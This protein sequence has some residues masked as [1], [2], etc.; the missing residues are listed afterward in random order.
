[1]CSS[2]CIAQMGI[3]FSIERWTWKLSSW[4][5]YKLERILYYSVISQEQMKMF[6][7][8]NQLQAK[9]QHK[10]FILN[11]IY[12]KSVTD[13]KQGPL[14]KDV[15][16]ISLMLPTTRN[17]THTTFKVTFLSNLLQYIVDINLL[18]LTS[19]LYNIVEAFFF[20]FLS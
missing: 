10:D 5:C 15:S 18:I 14:M 3:S 12:L 19:K 1:M 16:Q 7:V 4:K 20:C 13:K 6:F 9:A 2:P 11:D 8:K 17:E